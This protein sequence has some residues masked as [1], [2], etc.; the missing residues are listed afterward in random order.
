M[1][2][3][4]STGVWTAIITPFTSDGSLDLDSFAQLVE[5]QAAAGMAGIVIAGTTGEASTLTVQEK[6]TL[7]RKAKAVAGSSLQF[8]AGTG[9]S[10]TQQDI[11]LS[12]LAADAGA[13]SLLVVTP[14]Y[15]KPSLAGLKNHFSQIAAAVSTPICL[16][17]VPS[18]TACHL[19]AGPLSELLAIPNITAIKE[20]SGDMATMT[21]LSELSPE[22]VLLSG[23]DFSYLP[24]LAAGSHGCVSVV[25]NVFP[26]LMVAMTNAFAA[27]DLKMARTLNLDI[28]KASRAL[29]LDASPAPTKQIL[30][31]AGLCQ[32]ILRAPLAPVTP[33]KRSQVQESLMAI[34]A[35]HRELDP[36]GAS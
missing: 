17:H 18:R 34:E 6:L 1:T 23:D 24:S 7:I 11:E 30:A 12:K 25:G 15:S 19:A 32:D 35:Q 14:A 36:K 5:R 9:S 20:A 26:K 28:V 22:T 8:M 13:D 21:E 29:F 2:P 4:I 10:N 3:Q 16:Y 27:G 31:H 33:G